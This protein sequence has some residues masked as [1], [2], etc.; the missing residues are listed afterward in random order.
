MRSFNCLSVLLSV[1]WGT[2]LSVPSPAWG[3][4]AELTASSE[5]PVYDVA[6]QGTIA[7]LSQGPYLTVVDVSS[8]D[9]PG[10]IGRVRLPIESTSRDI[11]RNIAVADSRAY[12]ADGAHWSEPMV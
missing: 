12:I 3:Q 4:I 8:P 9:T 1:G 7:Y 11:V 10:V 2:L 5:S 6:V